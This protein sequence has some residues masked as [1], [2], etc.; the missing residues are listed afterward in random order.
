MF[1]ISL[2]DFLDC[3]IFQGSPVY[4]LTPTSEN[5]NKKRKEHNIMEKRTMQC[6]LLN[7]CLYMVSTPCI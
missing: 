1:Y 4:S 3:I 5:K 6:I 2:L 7:R